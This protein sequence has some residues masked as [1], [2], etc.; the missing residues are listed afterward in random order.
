M[1][2]SITGPPTPSA[3][4]CRSTALGATAAAFITVPNMGPR[5][6]DIAEDT[7]RYD[8]AITP[9]GCPS[10]VWAP[11]FALCLAST[12]QAAR[13]RRM[14]NA[15]TRA[16]GRPLVG[17]YALNPVWSVARISQR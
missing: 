13:T 16:I 3:D 6:G 12:F 15:E 5:L 8:L 1:T 7:N 10:D 9:P 4:R 11:I 17:A 14:A 2:H